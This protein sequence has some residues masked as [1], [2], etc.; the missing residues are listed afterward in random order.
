[1]GLSV[2]CSN[3]LRRWPSIA[4][5]R[6]PSG[7][8]EPRLQ[9]LT[10]PLS[11]ALLS[12]AGAC[13]THPTTPSAS[14]AEATGP[15]YEKVS[16]LDTAVFAAFNACAEPGQL[17]KHAAF[18]AEGVEFYHDK[19]GVTWSRS[20]MLAN[21][22]KYVCGNFSRELVPGSLRVY[23]VKD[24]GA[25]AQGVHRFCQHKTGACD[26]AAEFLIVWQQKGEI[27]QITRVLSY[28]HR[29]A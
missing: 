17:Q 13:S 21:T 4:V 16:A 9:N 19:G 20:E 15:L 10:R 11:L 12:L 24:F 28:G 27:W 14:S 18:F 7:H 1:M 6:A 8:A 26:G 2:M 3:F 29:P 5:Y 23:P 25:I 22:Q